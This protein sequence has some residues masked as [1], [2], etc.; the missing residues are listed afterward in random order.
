MS[1]SYPSAFSECRCFR[2]MLW[3]QKSGEQEGGVTADNSLSASQSRSRG[4]CFQSQKPSA[5]VPSTPEGVAFCPNGIVLWWQN[6]FLRP[7]TALV[8][9]ISQMLK[10]L[11]G[12][13]TGSKEA[14]N[15]V[16]SGWTCHYVPLR[17]TLYALRSTLCAV[18]RD[19]V[20][21]PPTVREGVVRRGR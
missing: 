5:D 18:R 7:E 21:I 10:Q 9:L 20:T 11:L 14:G 4:V 17:S 13:D 1:R 3:K 8:I 12:A 15:K 2:P 19:E 6:C 16:R